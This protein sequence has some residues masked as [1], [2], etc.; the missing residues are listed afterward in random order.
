MKDARSISPLF[1]PEAKRLRSGHAEAGAQAEAP[2]QDRPMGPLNYNRETLLPYKPGNRF[3][4]GKH[5]ELPDL[6]TNH[7][8]FAKVEGLVTDMANCILVTIDDCDEDDEE[9]NNL[10]HEIQ[11]KQA[12]NYGQDITVALIGDTG[13]G[14]SRF[15]N[16]LLGEEN[17]ATV[18]SAL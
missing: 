8:A 5:E 14:K 4:Y 12:I 15:I 2:A 6:P 16:N 10:Y 17:L 9:V 11:T 18:V 13:A 1:E 7:P 3:I